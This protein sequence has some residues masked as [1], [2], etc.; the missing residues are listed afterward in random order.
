MPAA[1]RGSILVKSK[2]MGAR[3]Y[4]DGELRGYTPTSVGPVPMGKHLLRL[5]RPGYRQR[6]ELIEISPEEQEVNA[7]LV[8][9][10][11]YKKYAANLG[12]MAQEVT[13][14]Q[15]GPATANAARTLSLERVVLGVV[16]DLMNDGGTEVLLGFFDVRT[17]RR[18]ADKKII[19]QGDEYGQL[20]SEVARTVTALVNA[21]DGAQDRALRTADP[22][23]GKA[24]TEEW[25]GE[26]RGGRNTQAER[27]KPQHDPLEGVSGTEDW[28]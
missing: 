7:D 22:L 6:G 12:Q 28:N 16:K 15:I 20:K 1:L 27:G 25:T 10:P 2:P 21:G 8:P 14:P 4:L 23:E 26:D 3:V 13:R 19:F 11:L 5:E 17:G 18:I 9:T 24:G